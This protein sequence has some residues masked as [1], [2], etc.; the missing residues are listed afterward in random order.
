MLGSHGSQQYDGHLLKIIDGHW[1]SLWLR[2]V[3]GRVD[4]A[5]E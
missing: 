4:P 2:D 5:G 1:C 3:V